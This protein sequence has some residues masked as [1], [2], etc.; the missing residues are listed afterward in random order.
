MATPLRH[1]QTKEAETDM[2]SLKPPRHI[3][4]PPQAAIIVELS[5]GRRVLIDAN[6]SAS[7]VSTALKALQS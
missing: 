7:L 3:S 5:G 4:T 1:R 2:C 6:A